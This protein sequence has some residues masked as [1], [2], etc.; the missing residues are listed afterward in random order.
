[1][2]S[3]VTWTSLADW[4]ARVASSPGRHRHATAS[5]WRT[6]R[7]GRHDVWQSAAS[8]SDFTGNEVR[9][10]GRGCANYSARRARSHRASHDPRRTISNSLTH[11]ALRYWSALEGAH[12]LPRVHLRVALRDTHQC[13]RRASLAEGIKKCMLYQQHLTVALA[14]PRSSLSAAPHPRSEEAKM[15]ELHYMEMGWSGSGWMDPLPMEP[16]AAPAPP[17]AA[18]PAPA[19]QPAARPGTPATSSAATKP[20]R[21]ASRPPA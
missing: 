17:P 4:A 14:H 7:L 8:R 16:P 2:V 19:A 5:A 15:A 12:H 11:R 20:T 9:K 10:R 1:M 13:A 3:G 6:T 21:K 18:A